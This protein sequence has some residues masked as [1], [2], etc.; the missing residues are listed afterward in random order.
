MNTHT[1]VLGTLGVVIILFITLYLSYGR[2]VACGSHGCVRS[3]DLEQQ[4]R[5]DAAFARSTNSSIPSQQTSLTTTIRRYFVLHAKN[6]VQISLAD[7][8][9][10]REDVLQMK[11]EEAIKKLGFTSLE[12]YDRHVVIPYLTQEALLKTRSLSTTDALYR[13][14]AAEQRIILF[15]QGYRW[16][17][18]TAQVVAK[19]MGGR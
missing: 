5:Y 6:M 18:S 17:P 13:Q 19:Y 4:K 1:R 2:P 9:R 15:A 12:E 7:A 14:L 10:Y 8:L 11:D 16:D 3:S